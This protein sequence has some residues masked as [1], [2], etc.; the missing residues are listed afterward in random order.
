MDLT[1][2]VLISFGVFLVSLFAANAS[3]NEEQRELISED[4]E[5]E[6]RETLNGLQRTLITLVSLSL[7]TFLGTGSVLAVMTVIELVV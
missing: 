3:L 4:R 7:I 2:I 6:A 5:S 1:S